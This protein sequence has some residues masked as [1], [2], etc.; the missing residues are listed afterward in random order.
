MPPDIRTFLKEQ[1]P[2]VEESAVWGD[3]RLPLR[4]A[5]Y[6]SEGRPPSD[7][8]SSVRCVLLHEEDVLVVQSTDGTHHILPGGRC[9]ENESFDET[10]RRELLEETGWTIRSPAFMGFIHFHHL[11]PKPEGYP[12][13]HPDFFQLVFAAQADT[14]QPHHRVL[15]DWEQAAGFRPYTELEALA[16]SPS[17]QLFLRMAV[18]RRWAP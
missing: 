18:G 13:P 12:Y 6:V 10:L 5:S 9:E 14:Y 2:G 17:N 4:I 11:N 8:I 15:G 7:S 16:L 3:G 1:K